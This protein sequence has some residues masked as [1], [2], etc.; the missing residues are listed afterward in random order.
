MG[1][2]NDLGRKH[3]HK[4][5]L[6]GLRVFAAGGEAYALAD[7][8]HVGVDRH[9]GLPEYHRQDYIGCLAPDSG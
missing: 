5:A 2:G 7:A 1:C 9:S 8:E 4:F 6:G 3:S